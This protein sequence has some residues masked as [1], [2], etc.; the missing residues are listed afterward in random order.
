M[1]KHRAIHILFFLFNFTYFT[2]TAQQNTSVTF[3]VSIDSI[4]HE[5]SDNLLHIG[6]RGNSQPL[7]W[8]NDILLTQNNSDSIYSAT[9][10]FSL[11]APTDIYFKFVYNQTEWEKGDARKIT[12]K[13]GTKNTYNAVFRYEP[14]PGNLFKKFIGN[15]TLKKD[16]WTQSNEHGLTN[17][18]IPNHQTL[19]KELNTDN[20]LLWIVNAPSARGHILWAYDHETNEVNHLSSFL[21]YRSGLGKGSIRENGDVSLKVQFEGEPKNTYRL[22]DYK[23]IND[24]EYILESTQYDSQGKKTGDFYGGNFIKVPKDYFV[25][26]KI[27]D[28]LNVL[29]D[30]NATIEQKV[31]LWSKDFAHMAPNN[32]VITDKKELAIYLEKEKATATIKMKHSI[33]D[34]FSYEDIV[35][36]RGSVNGSFS[37]KNSKVVI[38]FK[39]KNLFVFKIKSGGLLKIWKVI[40]N[41]VPNKT[42]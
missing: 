8:I 30:D 5:L 17:L 21:P 13:P 10:D 27:Q 37:L 29:D 7:S 3:K 34:M 26:Q 19:C 11:K 33:I 6:I 22:Y 35:I 14:R 40:Y 39:T 42:E 12:L 9:V 20:S 24:N 1:V 15:W 32:E 31:N 41:S 2:A 4:K 16:T 36:M 23:W 18:L 28:I 25:K 38:P